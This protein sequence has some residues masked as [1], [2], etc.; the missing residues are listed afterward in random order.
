M[1]E[2]CKKFR[3]QDLIWQ[4]EQGTDVI[5]SSSSAYGP[6]GLNL[7]NNSTAQVR[8]MLNTDSACVEQVG[9]PVSGLRVLHGWHTTTGQARG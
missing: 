5:V 4:K 7:S 1:D 3:S 8:R 2:S 9:A 6:N